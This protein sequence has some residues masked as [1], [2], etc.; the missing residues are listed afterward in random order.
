MSLI[1]SG[2]HYDNRLSLWVPATDLWSGSTLLDYIYACMQFVNL[3]CAIPICIH[4]IVLQHG[5]NGTTIAIWAFGCLSP[6]LDQVW[7]VAKLGIPDMLHGIP[8]RTIH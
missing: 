1:Q 5:H 2:V 8:I 6:A 3:C 4:S 7:S